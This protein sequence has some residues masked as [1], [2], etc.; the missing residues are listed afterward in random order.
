MPDQLVAVDQSLEALKRANRLRSERAALKSALASREL[1]LDDLLETRH[2]RRCLRKATAFEMVMAVRGMGEI[3]TLAAL[4]AVGIPPIQRLGITS[5]HQR[6]RLL[7]YLTRHHARPF[8]GA[9]WRSY[10]C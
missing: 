2:V 6:K 8:Y 4:N 10:L 3:K 5:Q 1:F 7:R 9:A